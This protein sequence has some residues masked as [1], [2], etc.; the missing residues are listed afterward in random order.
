MKYNISIWL[1]LIALIFT[2]LET[3]QVS[4]SL[5]TE[6]YVS[7]QPISSVPDGSREN[8]FSN[9]STA[10]D[11]I[12]NQVPSEVLILLVPSIEAY[13]FDNQL[14]S[15]N[16]KNISSITISTWKDESLDQNQSDA[17]TRAALGLNS[18]LLKINDIKTQFSITDID[19]TCFNSSII[20]RGA[21]FLL[22]NVSIDASMTSELG[23]IE[24]EDAPNVTLVNIDAKIRESKGLLKYSNGNFSTSPK[25]VIQSIS[26]TYS[27]NREDNDNSIKMSSV[28]DFGVLSVIT[29][30]T[31][32]IKDVVVMTE[33]KEL[34]TELQP[35]AYAKGFYLVQISNISINDQFIRFP[36]LKS[37][38]VMSSIAELYIKGLKLNFNQIVS[39]RYP[40]LHTDSIKNLII[41]DT[42]WSSNIVH[43]TSADDIFT[44]ANITNVANV[45]ITNNSIY[46]NSLGVMTQIYTLSNF[47]EDVPFSIKDTTLEVN[48]A[49]I[50]N[51]TN[52][53]SFKAF[54]YIYFHKSVLKNL[55]I[56]NIKYSQNHL[57]GKIFHFENNIALAN[58]IN[59]SSLTPI[60]FK[61]WN[62]AIT[63][64]LATSNT[65][66]LYFIPSSDQEVD[67]DCLKPEFY[68]LRISNLTVT[69]NK[70]LRE[71]QDQGLLYKVSLFHVRQSQIHLDSSLVK[72]Q[73]LQR[74]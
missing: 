27:L 49:D 10:F 15:I 18:S 55:T 41:D 61:F 65:N 38:F 2:R 44:I 11:F 16:N 47:E 7:N 20:I 53:G 64:N 35:F 17:P 12:Q 34:E 8:P 45:Q 46:N 19:I 1:T 42:E 74:I 13:R 36:S 54:N 71:T 51:N 21:D 14:F 39:S 56:H 43:N 25:L 52:P 32:D 30:G 23:F 73:Q 5:I 31:L 9:L 70:F 62:I 63:D 3:L 57:I 22:K 6:I 72:G 69:G 60:L 59:G 50:S 28:F 26:I 48:G 58:L 37:F 33:N 4:A 66:F 29:R 24:L 68:L 40:L 67:N